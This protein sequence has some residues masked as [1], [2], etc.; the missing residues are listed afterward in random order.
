MSNE[1]AQSTTTDHEGTT[2]EENG[3][4]TTESTDRLTS[5]SSG[6]TPENDNDDPPVDL[7]DEPMLAGS[8]QES[9][10]EPSTAAVALSSTTTEADNQHNERVDIETARFMALVASMSGD[11]NAAEDNN[12]LDF[13]SGQK[14]T[15]ETP[16]ALVPQQAPPLDERSRRRQ[17]H[18]I[19]SESYG[20]DVVTRPQRGRHSRNVSWGNADEVLVPKDDELSSMVGAAIDLQTDFGAKSNSGAVRLRS[21][22]KEAPENVDFETARDMALAALMPGNPEG[23]TGLDLRG[24]TTM[25]TPLKG[26]LSRRKTSFD[27]GGSHQDEGDVASLGGSTIG[28]DDQQSRGG[29]EGDASSWRAPRHARKVSWGG[30]DERLLMESLQLVAGDSADDRSMAN[31]SHASLRSESSLLEAV[32]GSGRGVGASSRQLHSSSIR[33]NL[34]KRLSMLKDLETGKEG[35]RGQKAVLRNESST[36]PQSAGTR[37]RRGLKKF[38]KKLVNPF[39]GVQE[40]GDDS[41]GESSDDDAKSMESHISMHGRLVVNRLAIDDE[42]LEGDYEGNDDVESLRTEAEHFVQYRLEA[43]DVSCNVFLF[44]AA[45]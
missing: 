11:G 32:F 17:D 12:N 36:I 30:A 16:A 26:N 35:V 29:T 10:S 40:G 23:S 19:P 41:D 25:A 13:S 5:V 22:E 1:A 43:L 2:T 39:W 6:E 18:D 21:N 14:M 37:R 34:N 7:G 33:F 24:H 4:E 44:V 31:D 3:G 8:F 45:T 27:D 28:G 15:L 38:G 20:S 9:S 42:G